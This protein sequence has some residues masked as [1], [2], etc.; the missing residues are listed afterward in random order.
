MLRRHRFNV[1]REANKK[2][3]VIMAM[4]AGAKRPDLAGRLQELL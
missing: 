4:L 1:A 3:F 2:V